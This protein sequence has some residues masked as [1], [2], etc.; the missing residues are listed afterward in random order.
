MGRC[1]GPEKSA[2]RRRSSRLRTDCF[3]PIGA[4]TGAASTLQ[5]RLVASCFG[6]HLSASAKDFG[7]R[8][9]AFAGKG[10]TRYGFKCK[11]I[12]ELAEKCKNLSRSLVRTQGSQLTGG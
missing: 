4:L 2:F 9:L 12:L 10:L 7:F 5:P 3:A 11:P 8:V 1:Y 6:A